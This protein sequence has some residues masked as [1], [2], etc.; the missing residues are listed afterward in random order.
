MEH[1][2]YMDTIIIVYFKNNNFAKKCFQI[3]MI[4]LDQI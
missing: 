3:Y 1:V 2:N 4:Y